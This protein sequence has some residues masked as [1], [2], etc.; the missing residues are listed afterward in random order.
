[1]KHV[2]ELPI[3]TAELLRRGWTEEQLEKFL[4]RNWLRV[5]QETLPA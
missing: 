4:Y 5:F 1:M 2:G 3:L